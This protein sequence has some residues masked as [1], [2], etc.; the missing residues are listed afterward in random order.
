[1]PPYAPVAAPRADRYKFK[2]EDYVHYQRNGVLVARGLLPPADVG[3]LR[4]W[5]D[6]LLYGREEAPGV[7]PPAEK[8]TLEELLQRFTRIHQLHRVNKTAEWGLLHPR[9]LDGVETLI[10]PDVLA[11][12]SMLFFNPPGQGGQGWHQDA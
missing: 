8:A 7:E 5:A 6:D 10:G 1:M 12:Q 9:I 2:V 4:S 3:R 11:L